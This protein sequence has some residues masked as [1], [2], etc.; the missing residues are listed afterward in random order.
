MKNHMSF[1][2]IKVQ[3]TELNYGAILARVSQA[4]EKRFH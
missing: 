2:G 4:H 1:A 3:Q